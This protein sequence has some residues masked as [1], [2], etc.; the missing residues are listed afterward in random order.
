MI[1]RLAELTN[2]WNW[3][4][5]TRQQ[6]PKRKFIYH[7]GPTNS[8]KTKHALEV[9]KRAESGCYLSP[10]RMLTME[11]HKG[12]TEGYK[13]EETGFFKDGIVCNLK[14]GPYRQISKYATHVAS[15]IDMCNYEDEYDV[16]VI[17]EV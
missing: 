14:T 17:D 15:V 8:G 9:L 10:L 6:F 12:L 2:P 16:A 5:V 13:D 7:V 4:P 11:V 3:F 1:S